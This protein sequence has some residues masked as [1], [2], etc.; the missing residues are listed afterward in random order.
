MSFTPITENETAAISRLLERLS[1][2]FSTDEDGVETETETVTP[3]TFRDIVLLRFLR[4]RDHVEDDAFDLLV[5]YAKWRK[6]YDVDDALSDSFS[7]RISTEEQKN[8]YVIVDKADLEDRPTAFVFVGR[9][10][11]YDRN[12]D[13]MRFLIIHVLERMV[14]T[15]KPEEERIILALDMSQFGMSCMVSTYLYSTMHMEIMLAIR[16]PNVWLLSLPYKLLFLELGLRSGKNSCRHSQNLLPRDIAIYIHGRLSLDFLSLLGNHQ[17]VVESS[18]SQ[19]SSFLETCR[20]E[21]I[22]EK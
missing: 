3:N 20:F 2:Y 19:E 10:N 4:G 14:A 5:D 17:A 9:H 16:F 8:K 18:D 7:S 21:E 1:S 12:V 6:K 13:E 15:A 11:M 22:Y